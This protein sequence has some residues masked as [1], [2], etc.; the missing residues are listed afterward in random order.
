M[1][2]YMLN[3]NSEIKS[4][5]QKF[6]QACQKS[7]SMVVFKELCKIWYGVSTKQFETKEKTW[8]PSKNEN[9]EW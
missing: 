2:T 9:K 8:F 7:D 4:L 6:F 5:F 1:Q 3:R